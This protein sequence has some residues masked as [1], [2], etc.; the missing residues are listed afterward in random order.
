MM[1]ICESM[2]KVRTI[3][4]AVSIFYSLTKNQEQILIPEESIR[5]RVIAN[6]NEMEDQALKMEI[7][8]S[9][10]KELNHLMALAKSKEEAKNLIQSSL[11]KIDSII[12]SYHVNYQINFGMNDFPVKEYKGVTY[13]AGKYESLVI[14][15]GNGLGENWWCVMFPPLCLLEAEETELDNIEYQF[16]LKNILNQYLS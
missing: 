10:E 6:S 8:E 16:F 15:L 1:K 7:K 12:Q 3:L 2:K 5:F 11:P 13:D 14:T 9:V 4:F